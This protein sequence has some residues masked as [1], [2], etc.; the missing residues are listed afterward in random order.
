MWIVTRVRKFE[1][2]FS[3]IIDSRPMIGFIGVYNSRE[4]AEAEYPE[5]PFREI[6]WVDGMHYRG[7]G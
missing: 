5:G 1:E 2:A 6:K 7:E 4:D 3:P